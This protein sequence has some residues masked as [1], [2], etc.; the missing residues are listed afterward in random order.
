LEGRT[1]V[2]AMLIDG[3]TECAVLFEGKV[4]SDCSCQVTFD[5]RRNQLARNIDVMLD[6][7][8]KLKPPLNNRVPD[9][10]AFTS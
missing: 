1:H 8:P 6:P 4:T 7:N 3:S 10:S 5:L 9:R 2:D